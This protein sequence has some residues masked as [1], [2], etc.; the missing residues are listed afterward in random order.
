MIRKLHYHIRQFS[1]IFSRTKLKPWLE[2]ETKKIKKTLPQNYKIISFGAGGA[3]NKTL[4]DNGLNITQIDIDPARNPDIV[5]DIC[6]LKTIKDDSIDAAFVMEVLEHVKDPFAAMKELKRIVKPGG[7]LILSTPFIFPIHD[8][9][10]DYFRYTKFGL[11]HLLKNF[12]DITIRNRNDYIFAIFT[13]TSRTIIA[14]DRKNRWIG[15]LIF[16]YFTLQLPIIALL[17]YLYKNDAATTGYFVT[18]TA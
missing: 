14:N 15:V 8:A 11:Q 12:Q 5:G 10:H 1:K 18:A 9:P 16:A 2:T 7:Q 4:K 3:I 6:D 13:L 17:S